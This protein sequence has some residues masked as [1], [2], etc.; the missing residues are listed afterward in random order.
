MRK[1]GVGLDTKD[2]IQTCFPSVIIF[3]MSSNI[4][5]YFLNLMADCVDALLHSNPEIDVDKRF[6]RYQ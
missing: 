2:Q 3:G 5:V 1:N 4:P 6:P